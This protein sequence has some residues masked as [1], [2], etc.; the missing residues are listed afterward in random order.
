MWAAV[1]D[2]KRKQLQ[3]V[4][5]NLQHSLT[6]YW[7][8]TRLLLTQAVCV[9]M[10][11]G[12]CLGRATSRFKGLCEDVKPPPP[13]CRPLSSPKETPLACCR[14]GFRSFA[15]APDQSRPNLMPETNQPQT[16]QSSMQRPCFALRYNTLH[17]GFVVYWVAFP[18]LSVL[19]GRFGGAF[20]MLQGCFGVTSGYG[21]SQYKAQGRSYFLPL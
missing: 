8:H 10:W 9:H 11:S 17:P 3:D 16:V 4:H 2:N 6:G 13:L 7:Q 5:G 1:W 15:G 19:W 14:F 18:Q 21:G 12:V 20:V